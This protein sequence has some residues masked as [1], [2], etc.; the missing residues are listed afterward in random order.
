MSFNRIP[1]EIWGKVVTEFVDPT[2]APQV[3]CNLAETCSEL[4]H[5]VNKED[6]IWN[7]LYKRRFNAP[8]NIFVD[9]RDDPRDALF[10]RESY[11]RLHDL[12]NRFRRGL[13]DR[14]IALTP[15]SSVV[16]NGR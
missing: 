13:Y 9:G 11:I 16:V 8:R 12:E 15:A 4:R 1:T 5:A 3:V 7:S 14:K 6:V 10:W 2:E